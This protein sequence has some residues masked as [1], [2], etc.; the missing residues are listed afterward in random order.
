MFLGAVKTLLLIIG[1]ILLVLS[2]FMISDYYGLIRKIQNWW[3]E[4][5]CYFNGA[6]GS[7]EFQNLGPLIAAIILAIL[8]LICIRIAL[9]IQKKA[10]Q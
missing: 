5:L 2:I 1:I 7:A 8:G 10:Q 6:L 9:S 3:Q 4:V